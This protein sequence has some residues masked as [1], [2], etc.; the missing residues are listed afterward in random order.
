MR[1][2]L[3]VADPLPRTAITGSDFD[4]LRTAPGDNERP[5]SVARRGRRFMLPVGRQ[6]GATARQNV[7]GG[8][9]LEV[10]HML[11]TITTRPLENT[12]R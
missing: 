4:W 6:Q 1:L 3:A 2:E 10:V 5:A 9:G 12:G 8:R 11:K 7:T